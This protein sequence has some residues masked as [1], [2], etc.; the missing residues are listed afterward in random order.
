MNPDAEGTVYQ[1]VTFVVEPTRVAAFRDVFGLTAGVPPTFATAAEFEVF[2]RVIADPELGLD[3]ARVVHGSQEYAF[4]RPIREGEALTVRARIES[5]KTK[6][7]T[8]FLTIR[9]DL[10]DPDGAVVCVARSQMIE[11]GADG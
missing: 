1:D 8:G 2:P 4:E 7:G 11:R 5:I 9:T 6:G 10:L 3:F